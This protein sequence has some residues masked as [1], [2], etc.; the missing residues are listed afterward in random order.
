M[1]TTCQWYI[2]IILQKIEAS[3]N[4]LWKFL[5]RKWRTQVHSQS[6]KFTTYLSAVFHTE[7]FPAGVSDLDT[8]LSEV[9][10]ESFAHDCSCCCKLVSLEAFECFC[11]S[12]SLDFD[13]VST[14]LA[15]AVKRYDSCWFNP[16][17]MRILTT[18]SLMRRSLCTTRKTSYT[19]F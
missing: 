2:W 5:S 1:L 17:E 18:M 19:I 6:S 15:L 13:S 11:Q 8:G 12:L 7:Q 10:A 9:K 4:F 3:L 16:N 14:S